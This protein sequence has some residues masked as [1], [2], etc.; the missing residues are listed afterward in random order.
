MTFSDEAYPRSD[1]V[2]ATNLAELGFIPS[3]LVKA[4]RDDEIVVRGV[5][6]QAVG[7]MAANIRA[8]KPVSPYWAKGTQW[9]GIK[10]IDEQLRRKPGKQ[11]KIGVE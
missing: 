8:V 7:Q 9:R 3:D 11:A 1:A 2:V 10:Y 4:L 5:D 6:K